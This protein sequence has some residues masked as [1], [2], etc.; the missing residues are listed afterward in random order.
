MASEGVIIPVDM[1]YLGLLGISAIE[2]AL[3]LIRSALDHLFK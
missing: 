1:S 2:R 3:E